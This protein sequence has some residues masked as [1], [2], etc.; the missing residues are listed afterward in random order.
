MEHPKCKQIIVFKDNVFEVG[1]IVKVK[2]VDVPAL[3]KGR[4][5]EIANRSFIVD[6]ST[7]LHASCREIRYTD[8]A[9]IEKVSV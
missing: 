5:H 4:I 1:N 9:S 3:I 7:E 2:R 6:T 8:V